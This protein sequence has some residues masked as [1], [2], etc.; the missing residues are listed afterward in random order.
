MRYHDGNDT[1][2]EHGSNP[3]NR[4]ND[5]QAQRC[6]KIREDKNAPKHTQTTSENE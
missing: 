1:V 3:G 2:A 4:E 6:A 5:K